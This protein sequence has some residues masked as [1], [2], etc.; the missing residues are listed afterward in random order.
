MT[1][2]KFERDI[3]SIALILA[4]VPVAAFAEV[5]ERDWLVPGDGLLTF[6]SSTGLEWLDL[7]ESILDQYP[8]E[9]IEDRFDAVVAETAAGGRFD[10]F[11]VANRSEAEQ[12]GLSAGID[13][14]T[15]DFVT[16]D[17]AVSG[18]I[19][20]VG[21]TTPAGD[22]R[23]AL[24]LLSDVAVIPGPAERRLGFDLLWRPPG[25]LSDVLARMAFPR[26]HRLDARFPGEGTFG[27]ALVRQQVPEPHSII[28]TLSAIGFL[29]C[30]QGV[31][32]GA[33]GT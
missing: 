11:R 24:G 14:S 29:W 23:L 21:A 13:L 7:T 20:L 3:C 26:E 33:N 16:N 31:R 8:G 6:D 25:G 32:K 2:R 19:D 12:L 10:G 17:E 18:L 22:S 9:L 27:V 5:V 30:I 4:C 28:A 1:M 15:N